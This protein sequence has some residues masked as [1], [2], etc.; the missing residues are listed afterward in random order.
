MKTLFLILFT[1]FATVSY[2]QSIDTLSK[3]VTT[4]WSTATDVGKNE[5]TLIVENLTT[6]NLTL[7]FNVGL[8]TPT[9]GDTT[10]ILPVVGPGKMVM[11][12]NWT[13]RYLYA[14]STVAG[15]IAIYTISG[16]RSVPEY[17]TLNSDGS[18]EVFSS[19]KTYSTKYIR[20]YGSAEISDSTNGMTQIF[21][22]TTTTYVQ[23]VNRG[24]D[25]IYYNFTGDPEDDSRSIAS[26][27]YT[28]Q[29][30][31]LNELPI[32]IY[33]KDGDTDIEVEIEAG[34]Y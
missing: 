29:S 27:E 31:N 28:Y 17:S 22:D 32:Y 12:P 19:Q 9:A 8:I 23:I 21:E 24:A 33:R 34:A 5:K 3:P 4:S 25:N 14:K 2:S 13:N 10:N 18:L 1:L 11:L 30:I 16:N 15:N 26:G 7:A 6:G 20:V